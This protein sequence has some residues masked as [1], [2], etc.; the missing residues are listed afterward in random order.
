MCENGQRH[1]R[2]D[3]GGPDK[4]PRQETRQ[5]F[6]C[7]VAGSGSPWPASGT[8]D[9]RLC[10]RFHLEVGIL[11]DPPRV[12]QDQKVPKVYLESFPLCS[13]TRSEKRSGQLPSARL[14]TLYTS[15]RM[16]DCSSPRLFSKTEIIQCCCLYGYS[17]RAASTVFSANITCQGL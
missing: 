8:T 11:I 1:V 4:Q 7:R 13:K 17:H 12:S 6:V 2:E 5:A 16:Q 9:S 3:L 10:G 14:E 15:D